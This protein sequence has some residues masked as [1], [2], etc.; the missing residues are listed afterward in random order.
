MIQVTTTISGWIR[1]TMPHDL[2]QFKIKVITNIYE[3]YKVLLE[4]LTLLDLNLIKGCICKRVNN[5]NKR[6]FDF[7]YFLQFYIK[8][9]TATLYTCQSS[10]T[11]CTKVQNKSYTILNVV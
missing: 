10:V 2:W 9:F 6:M 11:Q 4:H 7:V 5:H 1:F 8:Y 3:W